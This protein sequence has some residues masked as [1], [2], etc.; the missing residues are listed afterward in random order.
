MSLLS[1][2]MSTRLGGVIARLSNFM[3]AGEDV[4]GL[5]VSMSEGSTEIELGR[6]RFA[7]TTK[8]SGALIT[9]TI[10]RGPFAAMSNVEDVLVSSPL[11]EEHNEGTA[12]FSSLTKTLFRCGLR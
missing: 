5:V 11:L 1:S 10:S 4:N 9:L 6:P 3:T 12:S 7:G 2:F 8:I